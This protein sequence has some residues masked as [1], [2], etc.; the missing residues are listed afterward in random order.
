MVRRPRTR[1]DPAHE[2]SPASGSS[3]RP[4]LHNMRATIMVVAL[5]LSADSLRAQAGAE[6]GRPVTLDTLVAHAVATSPRLRAARAR[7]EAAQARVGP[8][9]ARPDPM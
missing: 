5:A 2:R 9:G 6:G 7:V 8:A 3:R 1:V 4:M